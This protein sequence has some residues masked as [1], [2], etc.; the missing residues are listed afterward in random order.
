MNSR[1]YYLHFS[2]PD[3]MKYPTQ[4]LLTACAVFTTSIATAQLKLAPNAAFR[5]DIQRVVEDYPRGF[6][7]IKGAAV[8]QNPQTVAYASKLTP[9]GATEASI[10]QYSSGG[11][12]VYSFQ[13]VLLETEEFKE[14]S[15]KYNW[16]Y[17]QLKG[18]NIKH[19][20]DNYTLQGRF[21]APDE[22]KKFAVSTLT[23]ASPPL[24]LQKLRVEVSLQ[25]EF[26]NW[27]VGLTV[28]EKEREDTEGRKE[29]D[30]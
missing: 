2:K 24:A 30:D 11:K 18:M 14:A 13:T 8:E 7:T 16:L 19:V 5:N 28:F 17:T 26:P 3:P 22:S 12:A 20:V 4:I 27:K 21:E 15:R 25:F 29:S 10:T 6:A 23:L 9:V 1:F